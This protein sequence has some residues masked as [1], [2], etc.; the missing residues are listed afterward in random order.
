MPAFPRPLSVA[1][2]CRV[3]EAV[4]SVR[5]LS[6]FLCCRETAGP[7]RGPPAG[8][9]GSLAGGGG[10]NGSGAPCA[11][12]VA[13]SFT[14]G[15]S[16]K[17]DGAAAPAHAAALHPSHGPSLRSV[18]LPV[19]AGSLVALTGAVGS[20]KSSLLAA[21][22]GEM[23]P[24]QDVPPGQL[25]PSGQLE[26]PAACT[27][28]GVTPGCRVAYVA[29][30]PWIP[31][32]T[33]RCAARCWPAGASRVA[34]RSVLPRVGMAVGGLRVAS[35]PSGGQPEPGLGLPRMMLT[36]AAVRRGGPAAAACTCPHVFARLPACRDVVL[37]GTPLDAERYRAVLHACALLPDLQALPAGDR[38]LGARGSRPAGR[39]RQGCCSRPNGE[40]P[41]TN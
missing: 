13:G 20:G 23:L 28:G 15:A 33:V 1:S 35:P 27:T 14:W 32:G 40:G 18:E 9:S 19:P 31:S 26:G 22:L 7:R 37:F 30:D 36:G 29:Q 6:D 41:S 34:A 10:G 25:V 11:V 16:A 39:R 24:W 5:R 2:S 12:T 21:A 38:T 4:V 17:V 8:P 3:V